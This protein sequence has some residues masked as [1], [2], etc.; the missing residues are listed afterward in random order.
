MFSVVRLY[1]IIPNEIDRFLEHFY[2]S[3]NFDK[4]KLSEK[5]WEKQ[6]PNPVEIVDIIGAYIE[7]LDTFQITMWVSIDS[8]V[9]I[10]VTEDNADELIRYLYERFP[11]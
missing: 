4:T 7:N 11:Y 3:S 5:Q 10:K 6:Y 1:S 9:F 8:G 2:G